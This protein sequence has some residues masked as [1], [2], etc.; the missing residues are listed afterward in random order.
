MKET[1]VR[2]MVETLQKLDAAGWDY[3]SPEVRQQEAVKKGR[4]GND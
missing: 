4:T 3:R 2:A 1:L